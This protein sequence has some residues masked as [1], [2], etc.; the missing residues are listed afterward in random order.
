VLPPAAFPATRRFFPLTGFDVL[1]PAF[2]LVLEASDLESS[3]G[4]FDLGG[5]ILL[6]YG[7]SGYVSSSNCPN[8]I[9]DDSLKG[10]RSGH[11]I[12]AYWDALKLSA[13]R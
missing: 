6:I 2:S 13:N 4:G 8:P 1:V 11:E 10:N 12:A 9:A 5:A 7:S 3:G